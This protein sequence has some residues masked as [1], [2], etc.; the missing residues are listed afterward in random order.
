MIVEIYPLAY[1]VLKG[2]EKRGVTARSQRFYGDSERAQLFNHGVA[3]FHRSS[4]QRDGLERAHC[5]FL[6]FRESPIAA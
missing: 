5:G 3:S 2:F 4:R 6:T 1:K